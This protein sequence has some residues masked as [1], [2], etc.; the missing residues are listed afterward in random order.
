MEC[1]RLL[2]E[3]GCDTRLLND[4][5][6]TARQLAAQLKRTAVVAMEAS[7]TRQGF[8]GELEEQAVVAPNLHPSQAKIK[9]QAGGK[10]VILSRFVALSVLLI[11][12]RVTIAA[13]GTSTSGRPGSPSS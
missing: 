12:E 5:G 2:A 1:A 4:V 10:I 6:L 11:L 9:V 13:E 7:P 8:E 3:A